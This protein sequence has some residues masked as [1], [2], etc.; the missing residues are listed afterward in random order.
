M[1]FIQDLKL[2]Y[3]RQMIELDE[4]EGA[5]VEM[6]KHFRAIFDTK[7]VQDNPEDKH[8]VCIV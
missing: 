3:Y 5:Y 4:Q 8:M 7:K 2:K 1:L 6:C